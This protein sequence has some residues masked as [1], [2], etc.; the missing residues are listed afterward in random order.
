MPRLPRWC[1]KKFLRLTLGVWLLIVFAF[2]AGLGLFGV[3]FLK[4]HVVEY[5]FRHQIPVSD[6]TF[7]AAAHALAEPIPREGNRIELLQNGNEIFPAMLAAIRGA[8]HTINFEAY[9]FYSGQVGT[10]FRD[11]LSQKAREGVQ[12]R[13]LLDGIGSGLK[14]DNRDVDFMKSAGCRFA[15]YHPARSWRTDKLNR[16]THRRV[17][18]VDGTLGF[19]GSVGFADEWLGHAESAE[20]WRDTAMRVQGPLVASLQA[21]FVD[22]WVKNTGEVLNTPHDFPPLRSAGNLKAQIVATHSFSVAPLALVISMA[23]ASAEHSILITN[24]YCAPGDTHVDLLIDA[25]KRGVDVRLLL[26]GKHNDQPAT[27]AAGR[28]SYGKLLRG[29]VKIYEYQPTMIHTKSMVIDGKFAIIGS[30]NFDARSAQ[31]NEELD[32]TVYDDA[33]AQKL[34]QIFETDLQQAKPYTLEDFRRRSLWDRATEYL[35][36]PFHSQL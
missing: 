36:L 31:L 26:P 15:Y 22:H 17:L 3:I 10:Q 12:V 33:F 27:K 18:V 25:V 1:S 7:F 11:A 5:H 9:L 14:L 34:Q 24:S 16:R 35:A 30:S 4:R 23:F 13:V 2:L 19:T 21:A 8:K 29:G 28:T 32:V 20:H 6:P